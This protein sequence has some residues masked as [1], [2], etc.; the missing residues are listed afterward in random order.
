[1]KQGISKAVS[2]EFDEYL[3]SESMLELRNPDE[4]AGFSNK[5]FMEEVYLF[6]MI[7]CL[8]LVVSL[9]KTYRKAVEM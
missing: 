8:G 3:K 4:L 2:K 6:G 7:V 1:M 9:G 5:L